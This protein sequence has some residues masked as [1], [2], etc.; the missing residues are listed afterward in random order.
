MKRV[1]SGLGMS[2]SASPCDLRVLLGGGHLPALDGLRAVAVF[3]VMV[4]HFGYPVP[5]DLGVSAFF[6]LSGFLITWLLLKEY[7]ATADVSLRRFYTRRVL[8]I[9]PAYYVFVS[10]SFA[11]DHFRS[12]PWP[13]GLPTAGL[14]YFVN[15][16]NA[17]HGHPTTS[18]AHTWSLAIEEQFYLL[19]PLL[20]IGLM[21]PGVSRARWV[22]LGLIVAVATWRS[23]LLFSLSASHAYLY[24]GFD[25]RFDSLAVGCLLAL[26]AGED[27]FA[28]IGWTTARSPLLP[29]VTLILITISRLGIGTQY[30]YSVGFGVDAVL[31]AVFIVQMLQLF[32]TWLWAWL[33]H[34]VVRY[35]GVIS[36]PLYLW[37]VWSLGLGHHLSFAPR[38][39]QF[40]AGAAACVLVASA[41]YYLVEKPFLKLKKR[42]EIDR[43]VVTH[44]EAVPVGR[45]ATS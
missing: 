9:F 31:L 1:P 17:L 15:Y 40:L 32:G 38:P 19:W 7:R 39:L 22:L 12:D 10:V 4:Y 28:P 24:N 25:T 36:Y 27:W 41:S 34:P 13:V 43:S 11:L 2:V 30:R 45:A 37:H 23:Y 3:T 35:L 20:F 18:I 8:R 5:G 21:R 26:S 14:L 16:F 6:V 42:F 33:E 44:A 29:V